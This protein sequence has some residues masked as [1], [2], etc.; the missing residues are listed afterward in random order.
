MGGRRA[1][2]DERTSGRATTHAHVL[3]VP[4]DRSALSWA[5]AKVPGNG[6]SRDTVFEVLGPPSSGGFCS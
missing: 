4:P 5:C 6:W 2:S 1:S 3:A